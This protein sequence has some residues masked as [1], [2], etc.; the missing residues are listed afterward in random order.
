MAHSGRIVASAVVLAHVA[1]AFWLIGGGKEA[2]ALAFWC[3]S[4][5]ALPLLMVFVARD[6]VTR[7]SAN[8][9][10]ACLWVTGAG[11]LLWGLVFEPGDYNHLVVIFLPIY[12]FAI[13][14]AALALLWLGSAVAILLISLW[15]LIAAR[16]R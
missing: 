3:T 8:I 4:P 11:L 12:E 10:L 5:Q 1:L 13:L 15:R 2:A 14:A 9:L 6:R 16:S 7:V